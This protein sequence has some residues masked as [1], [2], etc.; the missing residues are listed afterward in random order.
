MQYYATHAGDKHPLHIGEHPSENSR[1]VLRGY[2]AAAAQ[3]APLKHYQSNSVGVHSLQDWVSLLLADDY[4]IKDEHNNVVHLREIIGI[5]Q[6]PNYEVSRF[7]DVRKAGYLHNRDYAEVT[8]DRE[9]V[10]IDYSN[11]EHRTKA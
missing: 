11:F 7:E 10:D 2:R 1:F 9:G 5:I 3:K 6:D 8:R 4:V